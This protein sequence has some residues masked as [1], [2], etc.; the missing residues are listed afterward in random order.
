[1]KCRICEEEITGFEKICPH[2]GYEIANEMSRDYREFYPNESIEHLKEEKDKEPFLK[3][4]VKGREKT[5]KVAKKKTKQR[6]VG[7]ILIV[8]G[9]ITTMLFILEKRKES[10]PFFQVLYEKEDG[11][12]Q[13]DYNENKTSNTA[14]VLSENEYSLERKVSIGSEVEGNFRESGRLTDQPQVQLL[15]S[16]NKIFYIKEG[17]LYRKELSSESVVEVSKN[18]LYYSLL[19]NDKVLYMTEEDRELYVYD[20]KSCESLDI[21]NVEQVYINEA[22]DRILCTGKTYTLFDLGSGERKPIITFA[23]SE[24]AISSDFSTLIYLEEET[25]YVWQEQKEM[26]SSKVSEYVQTLMIPECVDFAAFNMDDEM[27][28]FYITG[29]NPPISLADLI[30]SDWSH[31]YQEFSLESLDNIY[32]YPESKKL[33]YWNG[34]SSV[35]VELECP[36]EIISQSS[37]KQDPLIVRCI[38]PGNTYQLKKMEDYDTTKLGASIIED[39][40]EYYKKNDSFEDGLYII[41]V[42]ESEVRIYDSRVCQVNGT[43]L[44][45]DYD[46]FYYDDFYRIED[47]YDDYF[48]K[49]LSSTFQ[50]DISIL[51]LEEYGFDMYFFVSERTEEY[52]YMKNDLMYRAYLQH[53]YLQDRPVSYSINKNTNKIW[54]EYYNYEEG[55]TLITEFSYGKESTASENNLL[56]LYEMSAVFLDYIGEKQYFL[57]GQADTVSD[58]EIIIHLLCDGE[59]LSSNYVSGSFRVNQDHT[60]GYYLVEEEGANTLYE[61]DDA[62]GARDIFYQVVSYQIQKDGSLIVLQEDEK[63]T[64]TYTLLRWENDRQKVIDTSV[65]EI[66]GEPLYS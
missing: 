64:G 10:T 18:V 6:I 26:G 33:Y 20:Y 16:K 54:V 55:M 12:Y 5:E 13:Y 9:L 45:Q 58:R 66:V 65:T 37:V 59:E 32:V 56:G 35:E 8:F 17:N 48:S 24:F 44:R 38:I 53:K 22:K 43:R 36:E 4:E 60:K 29:E 31:E 46:S 28:V 23:A 27:E 7:A 19:A 34:S 49:V 50:P 2:C 51:G 15:S 14:K 21:N 57:L 39:M 47:L 42:E 63:D 25:L 41:G 52:G 3:E 30:K 62:G 40:T 11:I 1:M 61:L